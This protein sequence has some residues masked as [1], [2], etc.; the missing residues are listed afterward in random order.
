M[1]IKKLLASV[2]PMWGADSGSLGDVELSAEE[3]NAELDRQTNSL[4]GIP[5]STFVLQLST[6]ELDRYD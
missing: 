1:D 3:W 5:S 2:G 4:L 6:G